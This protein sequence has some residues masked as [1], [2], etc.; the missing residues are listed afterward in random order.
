MKMQIP[1][2]L[3]PDFLRFP[4]VA[5]R[6]YANFAS[7]AVQM[8]Y[9]NWENIKQC[10]QGGNPFNEVYLNFKHDYKCGERFWRYGHVDLSLTGDA[11]GIAM[12][13]IPTFVHITTGG[14]N[15]EKKELFPFIQVDFL[16]R[17]L[18]RQQGGILDPA[19]IREVIYDFMKRRFPVRLVTYDG[20]QSAE[21]IMRLRNRGIVSEVLSID[22]TR[23]RVIVDESAQYRRRKEPVAN[24]SAPH[25][26]F[27][28]ILT[29][30]RIKLPTY[31]YLEVEMKDQDQIEDLVVKAPGATDDVLQAL[32]GAI[33]NAVSNTAPF[34]RER[35]DK[36]RVIDESEYIITRAARKYRE[37]LGTEKEAEIIQPKKIANKKIDSTVEIGDG[38]DDLLDGYGW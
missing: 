33:F 15:G 18:P 21:S 24:P 23:Y 35:D 1:I 32:V 2:E 20:Y 27:R 25:E 8:F 11:C 4:A 12:V 30:F 17:I 10:Y 14:N 28:D 16:G 31:R 34:V 37:L 29:D 3:L 22:R 9:F 19:L 36:E 26:L 38:F 13:H 6:Q 5:L 7:T